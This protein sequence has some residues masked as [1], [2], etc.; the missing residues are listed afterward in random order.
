MKK[1]GWRDYI[2]CLSF[3]TVIPNPRAAA[4]YWVV[5]HLVPGRTEG[6]KYFPYNLFYLLIRF[7]F[8]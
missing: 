2:I 4:Q 3:R 8:K 5:G 6:K 1:T 7:Y